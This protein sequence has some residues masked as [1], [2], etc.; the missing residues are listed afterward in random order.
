M[1][2]GIII[3]FVSGSQGSF[4]GQVAP[5]FLGHRWAQCCDGESEAEHSCSPQGAWGSEE[6]LRSYHDLWRQLADLT[7]SNGS[8]HLEL[9]PLVL[10]LS[11]LSRRDYFAAGFRGFSPRLPDSKVDHCNEGLDDERHSTPGVWDQREGEGTENDG[12]ESAIV[13]R[14]QLCDPQDAQNCAVL[15]S[16]CL[17][18]QSR[19]QSR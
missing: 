9:L 13:P 7:S 5:S 6:G 11:T 16:R 3:H 1:I 4:H 15:S 14:W 2:T 12:K 8:P 10:S 17:S 18:S 19:W